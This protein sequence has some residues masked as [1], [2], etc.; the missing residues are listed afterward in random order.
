MSQVVQ[1]KCPSC[2]AMLRI[3]SDWIG[4]AMRCKHCRHTFQARV[5]TASTLTA[6]TVVTPAPVAKPVAALAVQVAAPAHASAPP[7]SSANPFGFD[8]GE[9]AEPDPTPARRRK[10]GNGLLLL[11]LMFFFLFVLG[12]SGAGI[13]IYALNSGPDGEKKVA[14][15]DGN[16]TDNSMIPP[17]GGA[18]NAAADAT[19]PKDQKTV[20]KDKDGMA[21]G[22]DDAKTDKDMEKE[23]PKKLPPP[24]KDITKKDKDLVKKD[25]T[26][27][28]K[29]VFTNDPFPRRALLINVSNYLLF[30]TVHYGMAPGT[31][32]AGYPGSSTGVLRERLS[33]P[34]MNFPATQIVELSDAIPPESKVAKAHSTQKSVIETTIKDFVDGSRAQD[35][36][37]IVFTGHGVYFEE[38]KTS[39]L[40]P[41]DG[42]L[43]NPESL[44][45]LKWVYDQLA[46]CKAQQKILILDVFRFSPSRGFELPTPGEGEEGAMPEGF[47]KDVLNP[48]AGVQVWSSC[49]KEQS[50]VEL[51][52][53]G[54]FMQALCNALQGG[55]AMK[56]ISDPAQAIPIDELVTDVNKRLKDLL[57][58]EKKTQVSRLTGKAS[59]VVV[60]FDKDEALPEKLTLKPPT[61]SGAKA[62]GYAQ[63]NNI[64]DELKILPA[65]RDTRSGDR[66]LLEARNLPAFPVTKIDGYKTDGYQNITELQK[67]YKG[68]RDAFAKDFP[69]RAAYFEALEALQ[70][71]DKI[72]MREV[73]PGPI[74]PKSKALF[75]QEQ[76]DP[77]ISIFKLEQALAQVKEAGEKR[78]TDTSKRWQANFDYLQARLLSRLIYLYEYS[79]TL[80][81]I[82]AD[83]LPDLAAGQT[84]WRMGTGKKIAVTESKAKQYVKDT[85]KLWQRIQDQYPETPWALLAQRESMLSLGLAWRAKSD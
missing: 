16:K 80:G 3:P 30:N 38:E 36:I 59:D 69:L 17:K 77:G 10:K 19:K 60:A 61:A 76:S 18:D 12:G 13:V 81:R 48:P 8:H 85:K 22:A 33:R 14:K 46:K 24:V 25:G 56:G 72:R 26:T 27:V 11:A 45:P 40:I 2:Q 50:S 75:L 54:A 39:Y 52:G 66:N 67:K 84:G 57:T 65:V 71:S 49:Q 79:Y 63:I 73:L 34:P 83:D 28:K 44:V 68:N 70:E 53:G 7:P 55:G 23:K 6:K 51:E 58:P 9:S 74:N 15:A 29:P 41:I 42:N 35:R 62:A 37:I 21:P 32:K 47:D 31:F 64:L 43:K 5:C 4:A 82:R 20:T 1:A 78:D